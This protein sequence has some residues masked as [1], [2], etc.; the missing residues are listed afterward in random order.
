MKYRTDYTETTMEA[1]I[2]EALAEMEKKG[3]KLP[4][5]RY[6]EGN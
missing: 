2:E 6:N 4:E 3:E 1:M 5:I